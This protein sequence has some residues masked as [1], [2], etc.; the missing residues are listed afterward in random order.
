MQFH[1]LLGKR[2][3]KARTVVAAYITPL[4][5]RE[6]LHDIVKARCRDADAGVGDFNPGAVALVKADGE[7][8]SPWSGVKFRALERT[9]K[10]TCFNNRLSQSTGGNSVVMCVVI[11]V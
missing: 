9:F 1:E 10:R 7:V 4:Q 11:L 8:T 2:Q 5:L 3:A 6:G